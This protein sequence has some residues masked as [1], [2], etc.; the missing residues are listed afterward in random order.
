[1]K[2]GPRGLPAFSP[3]TVQVFETIVKRQ[4][5]PKAKQRCPR[6]TETSTL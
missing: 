2:L 3:R 4:T 5:L 6:A 1:M